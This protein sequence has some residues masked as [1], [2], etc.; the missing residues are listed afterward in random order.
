MSLLG[1]RD[2][3]ENVENV[4]LRYVAKKYHIVW[5]ARIKELYSQV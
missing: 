5:V 4:F 3:K 1:L 2:K